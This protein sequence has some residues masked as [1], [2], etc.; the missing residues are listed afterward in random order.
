M[1]IS[2]FMTLT[3]NQLVTINMLPNISSIKCN[4]TTKFV[5]LIGYNM[6][7]IFLG[8]SYTKKFVFIVQV[9]VYQNTLKR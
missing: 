6:R 3:G 5:Q 9:E 2:N 4:Q 1:L 7:N 8:K